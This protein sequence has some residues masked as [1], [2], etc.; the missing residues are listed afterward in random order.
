MEKKGKMMQSIDKILGDLS[1]GVN[2]AATLR[3]AAAAQHE[4]DSDVDLDFN[5]DESSPFSDVA[6]FQGFAFG[7]QLGLG[8]GATKSR[9]SS[10]SGSS[11]AEPVSS[12]TRP[13]T[14]PSRLILQQ[15]LHLTI[16]QHART[17]TP[18]SNLPLAGPL[19]TQNGHHNSLSRV[20]VN[21]IGRLGR[22]K[23][24]LSPRAPVTPLSPTADATSFDLELN[25]AGDLFAVRGGV[26]Q[27]LKMID[28]APAVVPSPTTPHAQTTLP[29]VTVSTAPAEESEEAPGSRP[30]SPQ[31]TPSPQDSEPANKTPMASHA[32]LRPESQASSSGGS[33]ENE[34][35]E[36]VTENNPASRSPVHKMLSRI[37]SSDRPDSVRSASSGSLRSFETTTS[38][39]GNPLPRQERTFP[40]VV[41]ID[42]LDDLDYLSDNSSSSE[43]KAP[44]GL[45]PT[46]RLPNRRDFEFVRRS[47]DSV[48]SMGII[49]RDSIVMSEHVDSAR[50]SEASPKLGNAVAQWQMNALIDD[51]SDDGQA[52]GDAEAALRKLEGQI[53]PT[54]QKR[55]EAKVDGWVKTIQERM[56][57]GDFRDDELPRR[58]SSEDEDDTNRKGDASAK[59]DEVA[60]TEGTTVTFPRSSVDSDR[61]SIGIIAGADNHGTT[62]TPRQTA[63]PISSSASQEKH[64]LSEAKPKIDEAVPE[65]ILL[66]RIPSRTSETA[67][68]STRS[69]PPQRLGQQTY[70]MTK[71]PSANVHRSFILHYRAEKL[72]QHFSIIDR[73]IFLGIKFEE[74]VSDEWMQSN[75]DYNVRDWMQFLRDRRR[76][77]ELRGKGKLSVLSAARARFNLVANFVVSEVALTNP[78]DRVVVVGKFIRIAWVRTYLLCSS[79][80]CLDR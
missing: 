72:V 17:I 8:D 74:L 77:A 37:R 38:F 52:P 3:K 79:L 5:P 25:A 78:H 36:S 12:P 56:A 30:A 27:Y 55:K 68:L 13:T 1:N 6:G 67:D 24:V 59:Q 33:G 53:N 16:L 54:Q 61:R 64:A 2:F 43:P 18:S 57:A 62:P 40:D 35:T 4:E 9:S 58:L 44:P 31:P 76:K 14:S 60:N 50:N 28:N 80:M 47:M 21:T 10:V 48:S 11:G 70:V 23:R 46:K 66:S 7:N 34:T 75:E 65:E 19:Q 71:S 51:L 22:W 29:E 69:S 15:P 63:H 39:F 32:Q 42:D 49:S 41:S 45:R 73:E 26:E 20:V